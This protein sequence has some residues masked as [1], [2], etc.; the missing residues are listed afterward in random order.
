MLYIVF[1]TTRASAFSTF[2]MKIIRHLEILIF[3]QCSSF[4][5]STDQE[6]NHCQ[7]TLYQRSC[8]KAK[9]T[10]PY[11]IALI[12][13]LSLGITNQCRMSWYNLRRLSVWELS[14][15]QCGEAANQVPTP[16]M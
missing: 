12:C 7:Q 5:T 4:H 16:S 6:P 2:Y 8:V 14:A 10:K 1:C 3:F 15:K 13:L 11:S 9:I